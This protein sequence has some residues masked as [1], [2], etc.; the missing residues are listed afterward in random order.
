MQGT[1]ST[2]ISGLL[3]SG[4]HGRAHVTKSLIVPTAPS[5]FGQ[6]EESEEEG[7]EVKKEEGQKG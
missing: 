4:F 5:C 1:D 2:Q 7:G 6:E 3:M